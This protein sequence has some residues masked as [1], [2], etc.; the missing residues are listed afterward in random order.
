MN[1]RI[2]V[3]DDD[4][5]L[6]TMMKFKLASEGF[7]IVAVSNGKEAMDLVNKERFDLL[8]LDIYMPYFS[9][10][11]VVSYLRN[12]LK[13]EVPVILLSAEGLEETVVHSF[14]LG[15]DDFL[16][17]PFSFSELSLRIKKSLKQPYYGKSTV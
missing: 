7:D 16:S 15:A 1:T 3:C 8:I 4:P 12:E 13:S 17:K 6:L 2:L 9:G 14:S 11:E 10:F 5:A